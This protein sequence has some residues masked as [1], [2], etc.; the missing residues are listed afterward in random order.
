MK[1]TLL[2]ALLCCLFSLGFAGN[3]VSVNDARTVSVN[4]IKAVYPDMNVNASDFV[5]KYTELDENGEPVFYQFAIGEQGFILIS[6]NDAVEPILAYSVTNNFDKNVGR[7]AISIYRD[8]ITSSKDKVDATALRE[9]KKFLPT[10][11]RGVI[12]QYISSEIKP[13]LTS[14]WNQAKYFNYLCPAQPDASQY[15]QASLDC[16]NHVPTGCVATAMAQVVYY[17]R[18]PEYGTGGIGYQPVHYD[19][20][21]NNNPI[22]TFTYPWQVQNFNTLHEY[23]AMPSTLS[24]YTGEVAKLSWH[25]GISVQMMYGPNASSARSDD[26][27]TALKNYW[28]YDRT[29]QIISRSDFSTIAKWQDTIRNELARYQPIYYAGNTSDGDGHAFILDGFQVIHD[30][31]STPHYSDTIAHIDHIDTANHT[32]V[33][34]IDTLPLRLT[35]NTSAP[36]KMFLLV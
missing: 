31:T 28:G 26:A 22:D 24:F 35:V 25:L 5:L 23:D 21:A 4:F 10:R 32:Y 16:D 12:G 17:Y 19:L 7:Y 6:A 15:Q 36:L 2:L 30:V 29:A 27:L 1:K 11:S 3:I 8:W 33:D 9:W 14:Q 13:L 20:D 34:H 18:Y